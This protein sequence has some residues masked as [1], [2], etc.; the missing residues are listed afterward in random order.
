MNE[1]YRRG[2]RG[3]SPLTAKDAFAWAAGDAARKHKEVLDAGIPQGDED[4]N[5]WQII[6]LFLTVGAGVGALLEWGL[7][8]AFLT[9]SWW[10]VGGLWL[11]SSVLAWFGLKAL[12]AWLAGSIMGL[13]LGGLAAVAGWV[14]LS[15]LWAAGL[16]LGVGA[17]MYLFFSTLE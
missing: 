16:G 14:Y 4:P 15:P 17:V 7:I 6:I 13:L 10:R 2:L 1:D 8:P 9:A 12:P 3:Q 5:A 11:V